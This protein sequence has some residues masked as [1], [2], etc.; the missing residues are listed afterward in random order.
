MELRELKK[1]DGFKLV[2]II[3]KFNIKE[4]LDAFFGNQVTG[5][6]NE[7]GI[8]I[9]G[10]ILATILENLHSCEAEIDDLLADLTGTSVEEI[11]DLSF[12]DY[13]QLIEDLV[14][15]KDFKSFFE[16]MVS[17]LNMGK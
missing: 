15:H 14:M 1:S 6:A 10:N 9:V 8:S 2:K 13:T 11:N 3:N 5:S 17:R 7:V 12:L 4:M 16:R